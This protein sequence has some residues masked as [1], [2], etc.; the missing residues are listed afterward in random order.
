MYSNTL[1]TYKIG[2][3]NNIHKRSLKLNRSG[4]HFSLVNFYDLNSNE[5]SMKLEKYLHQ[6]FKDKQCT[7]F[8]DTDLDGKTELF[9][10]DENDINYI[11]SYIKSYCKNKGI[12]IE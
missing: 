7:D 9:Y 4:E 1:S 10:L 8:L 2:I 3:T 11:D 6:Y 5:H 12:G